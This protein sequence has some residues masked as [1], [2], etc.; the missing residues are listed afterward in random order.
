[1]STL[2]PARA[3]FGFKCRGFI[4]TGPMISDAKQTWLIK[5]L[6]MTVDWRS[7]KRSPKEA[8]HQTHFASP[9][10]HEHSR[11][12]TRGAAQWTMPRWR[13]SPSRGL[14]ASLLGVTMRRG[15]SLMRSVQTARWVL[16][17]D[18]RHEQATVRSGEQHRSRPLTQSLGSYAPAITASTGRRAENGSTGPYPNRITMSGRFPLSPT[19]PASS[20]RSPATSMG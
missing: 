5:I 18:Q 9:C 7:L 3:W 10:R 8:D 19:R 13:A 1:M 11:H 20:G 16:T 17:G 14:M 4:E 12:P 6:A 2:T 15:L